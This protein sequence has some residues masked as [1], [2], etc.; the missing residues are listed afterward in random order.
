MTDA[1]DTAVQ[2]AL[3]GLLHDI[4]KFAQR[5]HSLLRA[6][7]TS[8]TYQTKGQLCGLMVQYTGPGVAVREDD[9]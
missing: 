5:Y 9:L 7:V 3:A 2:A 1:K 4:G 8:E 6:V